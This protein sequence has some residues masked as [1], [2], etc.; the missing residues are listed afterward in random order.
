MLRKLS[1]SSKFHKIVALS[2]LWFL[3]YP[4]LALIP[5][6]GWDSQPTENI[7]VLFICV[8]FMLAYIFHEGCIILSTVCC[9]TLLF[10]K[11][12]RKKGEYIKK[13]ILNAYPI[14]I[15]L[16]VFGTRTWYYFAY[17]IIALRDYFQ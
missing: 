5:G 3:V 16:V 6:Y 1:T 14:C 11:E 10:N 15:V 9:F 7:L 13:I 2:Y 8:I 17:P 12:E 4:I